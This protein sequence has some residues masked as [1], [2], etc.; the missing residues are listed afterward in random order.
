MQSKAVRRADKK[1]KGRSMRGSASKAAHL[2]SISRN[3]P[4]NQIRAIA[5]E[6]KLAHNTAFPSYITPILP[7]PGIIFSFTGKEHV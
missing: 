2:F 4:R 1:G 3:D 5:L 6:A 7:F